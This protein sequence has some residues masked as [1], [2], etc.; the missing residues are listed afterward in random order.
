MTDRELE[1]EDGAECRGHADEDGH[2]RPGHLSPGE[3][4]PDDL[5]QHCDKAE[6]QRMS[7]MS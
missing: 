4:H 7:S 6:Q 2:L 1:R 3:A 5:P